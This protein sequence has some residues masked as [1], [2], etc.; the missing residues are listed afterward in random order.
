M[1][2]TLMFQ[3]HIFSGL[4]SHENPS[5]PM[6]QTRPSEIFVKTFLRLL[7]HVVCFMFV[8]ADTKPLKPKA[9][10]DGDIFGIEGFICTKNRPTNSGFGSI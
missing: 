5:F 7:G 4:V 8:A 2:L 9:D 1:L 6:K 3:N 10:L